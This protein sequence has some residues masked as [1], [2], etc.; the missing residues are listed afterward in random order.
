MYCKVLDRGKGRKLH[1]YSLEEKEYIQ[2]DGLESVDQEGQHLRWNS[3]RDEWVLYSPL[4]QSRTFLPSKDSCPLC[5]SKLEGPLTDI[6]V[7]DYEIAV[8]DNRFSAL[9]INLQNIKK[10]KGVI[11]D[12]SYGKCEV[13]SYTP[14][15]KRSFQSLEINRVVLLM[16]V[17]SDRY[18]SL[19]NDPKIKFVLPF[20][21][22]GEEIGVTL[23]HPHGQIYAM[24]EI[25]EIIHRQSINQ[26]QKNIVSNLV[27]SISD[28]LIIS[29]DNNAISF[30]PPYA[31][32]PYE[33]WIAPFK[34]VD[35]MN[36]LS[37]EEIKSMATQLLFSL[38]RLD[39]LFDNPMPYTM[40]INFPPKG[41]EG[42]FHHYIALQPMKRDQNKLKYLAGIEQISGLMLS[43]IVPEDAASKLKSI[44]ID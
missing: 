26:K 5:A 29:K 16:K 14:D 30:V 10:I 9:S 40:A 24:S 13:I 41:F 28:D 20:E 42:N 11:S 4:R 17:W 19:M 27:K 7:T 35:C 23:E 12:Y 34:K 22:N 44:K 39:A 25:P 21:N 33:T 43:D 2:T 1:L 38:K 6:P 18:T 31:R 37:N 36:Q 3:L 15:H 8:F 32:Y